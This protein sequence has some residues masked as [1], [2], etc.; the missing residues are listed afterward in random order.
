MTALKDSNI[1]NNPFYSTYEKSDIRELGDEGSKTLAMFAIAH[2][3]A[4]FRVAYQN[5]SKKLEQQLK[6]LDSAIERMVGTVGKLR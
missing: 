6:H 5:S 1:Q 4:E 2:E 3:L